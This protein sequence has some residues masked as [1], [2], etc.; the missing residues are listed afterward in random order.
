M[1]ELANIT[2][3]TS[4]LPH[5]YCLIWNSA[6]LWL[7]VISDMLITLSY[8]S[9]P[10]ILL[11]F[12]RHYKNFPFNK[13]LIMFAS[14]IMACGTTHLLSIITIWQPLYLLEGLLK[15][16]TATLSIVTAISMVVIVPKVLASID[17][18][19]RLEKEM[20]ING[21]V[22]LAAFESAHSMYVTDSKGE[23]L[24]I[25]QA[26][27][28][29]TGYNITDLAGKTP[30]ILKSGRQDS[31][32]YM[33]L[34]ATLIA[35]GAWSGDIWNK[36]KNGEVYLD[37]IN[38]ISVVDEHGHVTH[39][40][41]NCTDMSKI[42]AYE[43]GL[44][45]AK[46][47]AERFSTL[48]SQFIASM[49]HEIR[50]PM[51]AI[52]GFSEL[53]LYEDM[54]DEIRNYL[55]D[56][57]KASTSLL[58]I[59]QDVLDFTKL[60]AGRVAIETLPFNILDLLNSIATL[61]TGAAQ[62][63]GLVFTIVHDS[64][65]P[66]E[67]LGDKLRLQQ[68]LTNLVGNAIKFT[69]EGSIKLALTLQTMTA[70]Q[71]QLLFSVTDTGIGILLED[72]DKLFKEF[73]Q[74]DGSYTRK[75]GGTGL[76]LVISKEL[77]ELMGGEISVVS[78]VKQGST[79]SFSLQLDIDKSS[80]S[81][82]TLLTP[83]KHEKPSNPYLNKLQGYRVLVVE[84]NTS[85]QKVIQKILTNLG[86]ETKIAS[87]GEEALALLEQFDF[88]VVLM[89]VHMPI[90]DGIEVTQRIRQQAKLANLPIIALSAGVTQLER[91]NCIDCGMD[92][93]IEK[94]IV[95]E[96]LC[97]VLELWLKPNKAL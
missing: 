26:F 47:K 50:T 29:M 44:I 35:T 16:L 63:K 85:S 52:I 77:V 76:G 69:S 31:T 24:S 65:I 39:Y 64:L 83:I 38:I 80:M 68:V 86:L 27:S 61:F 41:V 30:S 49:S 4:L 96:Q 56:I 70:T 11:Y 3:T 17:N 84:D 2:D 95:I 88:D 93:F 1:K 8:Y 19:R 25:N 91:N 42:N 87:R 13:L 82:T 40:V 46:E 6:L 66:L 9:I 57:Y 94:P 51:T 60:E 81:D 55:Q 18:N 67:L 33:E 89:D 54:P 10:L 34:W 75:Y 74:V 58:G 5:G 73:S 71:V 45:D 37:N 92:D 53:A 21:R 36:R 14:F 32:F 23:F 79:F 97:A 28:D 78:T 43:V 72:Q 48:K 15:L 12:I 20:E 62:Q 7:H 59:L 22:A 90:M